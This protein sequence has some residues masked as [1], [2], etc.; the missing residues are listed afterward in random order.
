MVTATLGSLF[1]A[2]LQLVASSPLPC[3]SPSLKA[4]QIN[5]TEGRVRAAA[6]NQAVP[7]SAHTGCQGLALCSPG[8][9]VTLEPCPRKQL[10]NVPPGTQD[11]NPSP[12]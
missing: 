8:A 9:G 1:Q 7:P 4:F 3:P 2:A 10:L 5:N 6:R 12:G 11:W